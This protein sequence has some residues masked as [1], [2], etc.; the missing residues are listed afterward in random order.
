MTGD[1]VAR[2]EEREAAL[3]E[4]LVDVRER[5]RQG[6]PAVLHAIA[7]RRVGELEQERPLAEP[8]R[9]AAQV[10]ARIPPGRPYPRSADRLVLPIASTSTRLA[11]TGS[12][13]SIRVVIARARRG[14]ALNERF[15][16]CAMSQTSS[17]TIRMSRS[18]SSST[19]A[20][21]AASM[22]AKP[23]RSAGQ[24]EDRILDAAGQVA[25][26][27]PSVTHKIPSSNAF[28]TSSS[29]HSARANTVLP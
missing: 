15:Q 7:Q 13:S 21:V 11:S 16:S 4:R 5:G 9:Q 29:W 1:R 24:H 10:G 27:L 23:G 19:S 6:L 28:C 20:A 18:A 22:L 25:R 3:V 17:T 26:R 12:V 14:S 2:V 8:R